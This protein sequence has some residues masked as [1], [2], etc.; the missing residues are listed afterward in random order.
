LV[1]EAGTDPALS[2]LISGALSELS[3]KRCPPKRTV[4]LDRKERKETQTVGG[5]S[6]TT[7][8]P[9]TAAL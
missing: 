6:S 8:K 9:L 1:H 3:G 5:G 2:R 4:C 7:V